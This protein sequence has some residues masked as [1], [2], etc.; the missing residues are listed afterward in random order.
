MLYEKI[1]KLAFS[2]D[3]LAS[4]AFQQRAM[5]AALV[6]IRPVGYVRNSA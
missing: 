2:I 3:V 6:C 4:T 5:E 1:W